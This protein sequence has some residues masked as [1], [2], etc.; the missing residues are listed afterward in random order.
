M[1][2]ARL[3]PHPGFAVGAVKDLPVS[4]DPL[5]FRE[6]ASLSIDEVLDEGHHQGVG[7]IGGLKA[8]PEVREVVGAV[9]IVDV[10]GI[11]YEHGDLKDL[12]IHFPGWTSG[13]H[14][15]RF[16]ECKEDSGDLGLLHGSIFAS[17][18]LH[19]EGPGSAVEGR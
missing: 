16:Y 10:D 15:H 6:G 1:E 8:R 3:H 14:E 5:M 12:A 19:V 4:D 11:P 17:S 13:A 18:W 2:R 7:L 9:V